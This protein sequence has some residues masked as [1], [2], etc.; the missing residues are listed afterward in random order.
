METLRVLFTWLRA[1]DP[2]CRWLRVFEKL[3]ASSPHFARLSTPS[4]TAVCPIG[5]GKRTRR[6]PHTG[7]KARY[8]HFVLHSVAPAPEIPAS[9]DIVEYKDGS[10]SPPWVSHGERPPQP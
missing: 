7:T 4:G 9:S 2:F 10:A 8:D 1:F 3:G 5:D 6:Q